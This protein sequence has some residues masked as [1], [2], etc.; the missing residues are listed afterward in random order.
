[1]FKP[2]VIVA[3]LALAMCLSQASFAQ[4][5][6]KP[7]APPAS[8]ATPSTPT[9]RDGQALLQQEK[10]D[11]AAEMFRLIVSANPDN[12]QAWH[13]L[14]YSLHAGGHIDEALP[15]HLMAAEFPANRGV[16]AYNVACVYAI[17]GKKDQA[18]A[19]LEKAKV[20]GFDDA[21][22]L[23]NDEDMTNL[24]SDPRF[25]AFV[26][27]LGEGGAAGAAGAPGEHG[28]REIAIADEDGQGAKQQT[29]KGFNADD[30]AKLPAE[31]QL[32]FWI[33]S[34][35]VIGPQGK[36][37][38]SNTIESALKGRAIIEHWTSAGGTSGTSINYYDATR[39]QWVQVWIDADGDSLQTWG[40]FENGAM[41]TTGEAATHDGKRSKMR[42]TLTPNADGTITQLIEESADEGNTWTTAFQGT[43]KRVEM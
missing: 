34:W 26:K 33:G 25:D 12:A 18:F 15:I 32:D 16:A 21:D 39:K 40:T 6:P 35:D 37:A 28:I 19:W 31:R 41:R 9:I 4:D 7:A 24:K 20:G 10:F 2:A 38:G 14:G 43:Y 29:A 22:Q 36:K 17:K 23:A 42:S 1:M 13:Y 8:D 3:S 30:I 11:E 27:S 5:N